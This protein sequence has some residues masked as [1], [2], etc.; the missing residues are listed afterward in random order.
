MHIYIGVIFS[1]QGFML[2]SQLSHT[3]EPNNPN[4]SWQSSYLSG[5]F[6]IL[7]FLNQQEDHTNGAKLSWTWTQFVANLS[8][9]LT[10][11]TTIKTAIF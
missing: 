1:F 3:Q 8:L 7:D 9:H 11:H 6:L 5:S 10:L 2:K 4:C